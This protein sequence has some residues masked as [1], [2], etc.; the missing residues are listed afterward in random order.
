MSRSYR[1]SVRECVSKMIRAEDHVSTNLE[2]LEVLPPEQMAGL[3]SDELERRGFLREADGVLVRRDKDVTVTVDPAKGTVTVR[4]EAE[5]KVKL[6]ETRDGRAFDEAGQHAQGVRESLRKGLQRD[7]QKQAAEK[8]SGLQTQVTDRLEAQLGAV[9]QE[10]DQAV[11]RVTAEAL[12]R[13]AAQLGRIKEITED[14]QA[15]SLTIVVEV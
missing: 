5:E 6:E 13:K 15:G 9:R 3:L 10:L 11:N 12:K 4:A 2:M 8:E 7:L 1:I 14:P